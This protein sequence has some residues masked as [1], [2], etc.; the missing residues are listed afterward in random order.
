M[1]AYKELDYQ[2]TNVAL[3]KPVDVDAL[4]QVAYNALDEIEDLK[5][6]IKNN[7]A[8]EESL[9][10]A[11][12]AEHERY[13]VAGQLYRYENALERITSELVDAIRLLKQ[14]RLS[15]KDRL[16][17]LRQLEYALKP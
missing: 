3:G 8:S 14:E 15:K 5:L 6:A 4:F 11:E 2:E 13:K 9:R 17:V 1:D 16:R 12:V 10:A 7:E